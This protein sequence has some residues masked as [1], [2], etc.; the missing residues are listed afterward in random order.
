MNA[1][2]RV[3]ECLKQKFE[4]LTSIECRRHI[5]FM[6]SAVQVDIQADPILHRACAIDLV[7]YCK[8]VPPGEGRS[9]NYYSL[10]L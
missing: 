3:E 10:K 7:T 1:P 5:A 8:E 6:I 2:G 9:M 4:E